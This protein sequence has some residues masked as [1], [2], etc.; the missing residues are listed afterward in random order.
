MSSRI[1]RAPIRATLRRLRPLALVAVGVAVLWFL[2]NAAV[3]LYTTNLWF[4]SLHAGGVY[5]RQLLTQ[6]VMFAVFGGA[7]A[8]AVAVTLTL[9][10]RH[11][12]HDGGGRRTRLRVRR[13]YGRFVNPRRHVATAVVAVLAGVKVGLAAAAHWQLWL[14]WTHATSFGIKDPQFHRDYSYFAF[15]YPMHRYAL[16]V[17]FQIVAVCLALLLIAG[18]LN[19]GLRMRERPRLRP[20]MRVHLCIL[21]G[22]L[23][24]LKAAAYWLDRLA[25]ATSNRGVVTGPSYTDIHAVLPSKLVLLV[26]ALVVAALFFLNAAFRSWKATALGVAALVLGGLVLGGFVPWLVQ[27]YHVKPDAQEAEQGSIARN[28]AATRYAYGLRG[29]PGSTQVDYP[30]NTTD[31]GAELRRLAVTSLQP[32]ILDPNQLSPTFTQLQQQRSFYRFKSTLDADRY[33]VGG[34]RQDVVVA[35]REL[36]LRGLPASQQTWS[37]Q[38]LV[39]THGNGLVAAPSDTVGPQ[40]TPAFVEGGLPASGVLGRFQPRVYFG[41]LSPSYS[42]VGAPPGAPAH[43]LDRP[44]SNAGGQ[45]NTTYTGTGGVPIGSFFRRLLYA[46]QMGDKNILFSSGVNAHSRLLYIRDPRQRV[47]QVAPWL[48]LDGDAYPTVVNGRILW[49]VDGY[50]TLNS[51]PY[52]QQQNLRAAASDSYV[53]N[54]SSVAQ[55]NASIN[56]I[57]NSV[58]A[59]VDAYDGTVTLYR[60]DTE[61]GQRDPVLDTWTKAFP[62]LVKPASAIPAALLP[63]L[64][65]PRD[66]FNVQ[67]TMLT[68]YHV[69]DPRAFYSGSDFWKVPSDPT[70][71]GNV[72]Q[73]SYYLTMSPTGTGADAGFALTTPFVSLNGRALTAYLSV[74]SDPGPGYGRL[75]LLTVGPGQE[76]PGQIRNDIE[77]DPAVAQQLTLLRGGGSRVVLGNLQTV[78]IG[79]GLLSIEPIYSRAAGGTSFPILRRVVAVFDNRIAFEPSLAAALQAVFEPGTTISTQQLAA[80]VAAA[81]DAQTRA[82]AALAAGDRRTY[83]AEERKLAAA[84][85]RIATLSNT[86]GG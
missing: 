24:L 64:R 41:Q 76:G 17:A 65:Y 81:Q 43:E 1:P 2:V 20:N 70:V 34:Q 80:A 68:R 23:A 66:M 52:S 26:L 57:R 54:G 37:N 29:G 60:W 31:S 71:K 19:G 51:L 62:G 30:G 67:R 83:A 74:D 21:L 13:R 7:M 77:S 53:T 16:T 55:R 25:T 27:T 56:Y 6:V 75:T 8:L 12:P 48:T 50:T 4:D 84:L 9:V 78:P 72:A 47:H 3:R 36:S 49:V 28:I 63:H 58:K 11:T 14:Q 61:T 35:V 40:G 86:G 33:G 82:Q 32:Q 45:V 18:F 15:V 79:G 59:T 5:H 38:H 39:Y 22:I 46:W 10:H 42:I 85:A 69:T 44:A 73:P